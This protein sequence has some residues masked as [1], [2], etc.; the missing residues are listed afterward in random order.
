MAFPLRYE[1][2]KENKSPQEIADTYNALIK[3]SFEDF[4]ISFDIYS[5][6]SNATHH[7]T[8]SDFFK[9]LY[10]K[11]VFKEI[12]SE[13]YYDVETQEFLADRYIKGTCPNC[14]FEEA[15][16]DQCERCGTTLSPSELINP[17][18]M[19][20][21]SEPI[22][23]ET[24]HWYLPLDEFEPW[25]RQWILEGHKEWKSNVYGQCKSWIDNG[26]QP[27]AVTRDLSWGVPVPLPNAA[28]KVLYVWF[29]APIGYISATKD[30]AKKQQGMGTILEIR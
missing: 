6:T 21:G 7:K 24:K 28:G 8:A 20:S 30:W 1:Q 25:L 12:V 23:K 14:G 19:L 13:Q 22:L 4:G 15:Y 26:L 11:G 3:K 10:E 27:R 5:R 9:V 2:R 18:S 17:K 29:D 16:G